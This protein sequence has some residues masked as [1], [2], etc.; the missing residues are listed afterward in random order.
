MAEHHEKWLK[1]QGVKIIGRHTLRRASNPGYVNWD[2]KQ[3]NSHIDW[4]E[5]FTTT[6][7]DVYQVELDEHTIGKFER[8]EST[9]KYALQYM[10]RKFGGQRYAAPSSDVLNYYI[11]NNER[12]L[13]LLEENSMYKDAW[14]EFQAIRALLGETPHWP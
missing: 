7:E 14:K 13:V 6:N 3:E 9:V 5:Q 4:S 1:T 2:R 11:D 10:D 12:H 8:F